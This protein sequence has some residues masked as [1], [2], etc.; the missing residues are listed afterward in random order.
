MF[1]KL[2]NEINNYEELKDFRDLDLMKLPDKMKKE[3]I[4]SLGIGTSKK[5]QK[6]RKGKGKRKKKSSF[7]KRN[8]Q[9]NEVVEE[10]PLEE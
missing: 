5:K 8:M 10:L 6:K 2:Q 9:M 7:M 3:I 1:K 4:E